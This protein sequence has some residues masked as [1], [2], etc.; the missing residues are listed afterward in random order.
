MAVIIVAISLASFVSGSVVSVFWALPHF[1]AQKP[2]SEGA[3]LVSI[4]H[5]KSQRCPVQG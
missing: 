3:S 2:Y 5:A 4:P 1:R